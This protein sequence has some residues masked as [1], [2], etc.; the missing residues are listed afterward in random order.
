M[1]DKKNNITRIITG[2]IL[3]FTVLF[4]MMAGGSALFALALLVIFLATKEYVLILQNK[5]FYPSLKLMLISEL[6]LAFLAYCNHFDMLAMALTICSIST[7]MWVLFKGKQPY[8]ANAATTILGFIYGGLFPLYLILIR[9]I[10][11]NPTYSYLLKSSGDGVGKGYII[12]IF[13]AVL[14]TDT[15]CYYFGSKFGK[16]KLAPVISPNK[17][18]EGSIGGTLSAMFISLLIGHFI[19]LAWYHCVIVGALIAALAQIGDL[20]ESMLKRDAGVKDS[21]NILPGHGG[22]LD[23]T[24]SYVFTLPVLYY[25]FQYVVYDE[26]T[27]N[28]LTNLFKGF[29]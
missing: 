8:I 18:I 28:A 4:S 13:F 11:S 9:D 14:F 12:L 5:G 21:G 26:N 24:D 10:G 1:L 27:I 7:F 3:G 19:N 15:G 2:I 6:F 29:W 17:T 20:C 25:Y 22:F 23:R 16:H